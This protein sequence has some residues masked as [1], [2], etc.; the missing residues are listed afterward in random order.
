MDYQTLDEHE[1]LALL[2]SDDQRAFDEIYARFHD[3]LFF[4]AYK[5][6]QDESESRD[7]LQALFVNLWTKRNELEIKGT[8][9][10]YLHQGIKYG[11]LNEERRKTVVSKYKE[12]LHKY[13]QEGYTH[14]EEAVFEKELI[15]RLRGLAEEMP[16][17]SGQ[18]FLMAHFDNLSISQIAELLDIS[19]KTVRNL[20]SK[21]VK[22][23]RLKLG[24][25]IAI[26]LLIGA[27]S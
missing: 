7:I 13:L 5:L 11:F 12:S 2:R 22:D 21:A 17:K 4:Y 9:L 1:L 24:L 8:I 25:A 16:G 18:V 14:T 26:F 19:E 6:T 27:N 15:K 23:V 20:Q 10:S 3:F